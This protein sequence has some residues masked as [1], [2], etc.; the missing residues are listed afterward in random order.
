MKITLDKKG[1]KTLS[2]D[3]RMY[4]ARTA[5]KDRREGRLISSEYLFIGDGCFKENGK[6]HAAVLPPK[7]LIIGESAFEGCQFQKEVAFPD[8]VI[9]IMDRAFAQNHRLKRVHFPASLKKIGR[10]CYKECSALLSAEFHE[11]SCLTVI[12]E[13]IFDSCVRLKKVWLPDTVKQIERRA[14]YRCKEL[15]ELKLP[16]GLRTIGA[17][18]F[19]FCGIETLKL[20]EGLVRIEES[21]FLRCKKL[22]EVKLPS[23]VSYIGR[24]AF[25]G[26]DWLDTLEILHDPAFIGDWIINKSCTIRCYK[27]SKVDQYCEKFGFKREYAVKEELANE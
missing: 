22:R 3:S 20:P 16:L 11:K 19:Y 23:S 24:W 17:E 27:G 12:P 5:E 14:F 25:H 10:E 9:F 15:K 6:I 1:W 4:T 13:G 26:C 18:A 8:S 21:A 7:C 2:L